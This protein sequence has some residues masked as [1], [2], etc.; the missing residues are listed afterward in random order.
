MSELPTFISTAQAPSTSG[1]GSLDYVPAQD[2]LGKVLQN[3]GGVGQQIAED[4]FK[5]EN[6]QAVNHAKLGASLK[7]NQL[8][9]ELGKMDPK[10]AL[11]VAPTRIKQI[12]DEQ[13]EGL[14]AVAKDAFSS[15]FATMNAQSQ[16]NIQ[17]QAIKNHN[18]KQQAGL[19]VLLDGLGKN[20]GPKGRQLTT[21]N[22]VATAFSAINTAVRGNVITAKKGADLKLKFRKTI[23]ENTIDRWFN[24]QTRETLMDAFKEMD[25]AKFKDPEI[26]QL[27]GVLD[28]DRKMALTGRAI[29]SLSR[30]HSF[31]DKLEKQKADD[32]K[33][34]ANEQI[35]D[36]YKPGQNANRRQEILTT[37]S[38]N[39]YMNPSIIK[40]MSSDQAG[41]TSQFTDFDNA[42]F[43]L[44]KRIL[45][46]DPTLTNND[47]ITADKIDISSKV[48]L[49]S[50]FNQ[51][52]SDEMKRA[53]DILRN[54]PEF[55][56]KDRVDKLLNAEKLDRDQASLWNSILIAES[57]AQR[58][59][60]PYDAIDAV[61]KAIEAYKLGKRNDAA[62]AKQDAVSA[63]KALG[64]NDRDQLKQYL[65][66]NASTLSAAEIGKIESNANIAFGL[67]P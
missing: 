25:E 36:F 57:K 50:L 31:E 48:Q 20:I 10:Q 33:Q 53:Q 19:A 35:I 59:G 5:T 60:K 34:E 13:T 40:S 66:K 23:A 52:Q 38:K 6:A 32:K 21:T 67:A 43:P 45:N 12:Q 27:W 47:I 37:L 3:L 44:M 64:I 55:I 29:T 16:I 39:P 15:T 41:R 46:N 11:S 62:Q 28:E 58:D 17:A 51:D 14:S 61:T 7:L 9:V 24:N 49:I 42:Y 54:H 2:D 1:V 63:L 56:T 8:E 4:M 65:L 26:Q 22:S 30:L 18:D